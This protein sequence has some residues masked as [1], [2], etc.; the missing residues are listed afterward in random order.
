MKTPTL[1]ESYRRATTPKPIRG[2]GVDGL[3]S[4]RDRFLTA[5]QGRLLHQR[6]FFST[7]RC[8]GVGTLCV[9]GPLATSLRGLWVSGLL[10]PYNGGPSQ[11]RPGGDDSDPGLA[12]R[13]ESFL[14][15]QNKSTESAWA[16]T[17][18]SEGKGPENPGVVAPFAVAGCRGNRS[19]I[20]LDGRIHL[21]RARRGQLY[22]VLRHRRSCLSAADWWAR[23]V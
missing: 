18:H 23:A 7:P 22:Q 16:A 2:Q 5:K 6:H 10:P 15:A 8:R 20:R 13:R 9:A 11:G 21:P 1:E 3:A 4:Q 12:S 17:T 19:M 14:T